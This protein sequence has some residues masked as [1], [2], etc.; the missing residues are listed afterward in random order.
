MYFPLLIYSAP[1]EKELVSG[2]HTDGSYCYEALFPP[3]SQHDTHY[4]M[5]QIDRATLTCQ[6]TSGGM[7]GFECDLIRTFSRS[8]EYRTEFK[9][10]QLSSNRK[11]SILMI[12]YNLLDSD[13][14]SIVYTAVILFKQ[15]NDAL[16]SIVGLS[17]KS[18]ILIEH[19]NWFVVQ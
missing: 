2:I 9:I 7:S 8:T 10:R 15:Y 1:R 14:P 5:L 11:Y 12:C 18:L 13:N 16:F 4:L 17:F 6:T 3:T 19:I